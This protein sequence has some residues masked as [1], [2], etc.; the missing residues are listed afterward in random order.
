MEPYHIPVMFDECMEALQVKD[1]GIYFDGTLGGGSHT[2]GILS[3]GG[4]VIAVDRDDDAIEYCRQRFADSPFADHL[5]IVKSNFKDFSH[6]IAKLGVKKIDGALLDLGI[7]SHQIS[8]VERGFTFQ[9]DAPLDMRMDREQKLSAKDIVNSWPQEKIA[10][11]IFDY[12]EEKFAKRIAANICAF[13]QKKEIETTFEL[14]DII[15][16]SVDS[17]AMKNGHPAKRTFQAL[18]IAVNDELSGLGELIEDIVNKLN[19]G[20]RIAI[21]SFHSLE[22]RI[23]KRKFAFMAT[24]CICDKTLPVCVCG[25]KADI[26]IIGKYSP[27]EKELD[28]NPRSSSAT[29]RV[30]EKLAKK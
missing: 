3:R 8:S 30:A 23:V 11:V 1:D 29:L 16:H 9:Q 20:G 24:D 4:R 25:H 10:D 19:V 2:A 22:D 12:G 13:R 18:R 28:K 7:S 14:V 6:I 27:S 15:K 21:I 17:A 5:T 26:K